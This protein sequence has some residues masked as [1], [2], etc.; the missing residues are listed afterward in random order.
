MDG[1]I[2]VFAGST[3]TTLNRGVRQRRRGPPVRHHG[4]A[5]H[6]GADAPA[7]LQLPDRLRR[8]RA[9]QPARGGE[10]AQRPQHRGTRS[11]STRPCSTRRA[12]A[13][14]TRRRTGTG[15]SRARPARTRSAH[16]TGYELVPRREQHPLLAARLRAAPA[17]AVRAAPALGHALPRRRSSTRRRLPEPGARR[18]RG[19][20]IRR[21]PPERRRRATSSSGTRPGYPLDAVEDFP[22]MPTA[23]IGF[24]L[25]PHG[26]FD[27]NPALDVP[28]QD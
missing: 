3:G 17:G 23:T 18:A 6:R 8:R 26:F 7:L 16:P 24:S 1:G 25:R 5:E 21:R 20:R 9:E 12:S 15:W 14:S 22:V 13:T 28:R 11:S 2:D 19:C 10:H 4:R 27:E